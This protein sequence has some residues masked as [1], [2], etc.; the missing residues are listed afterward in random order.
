MQY[1]AYLNLAERLITS[2]PNAEGWRT[3][4]SRSYYAAFHAAIDFLT[5][6][7]VQLP[8]NI[9][10]DHVRVSTIL[11]NC[12]DADIDTYGNMLANLRGSRVSADYYFDQF[13]V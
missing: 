9:G 5:R 1:I 10:S 8:K 13:E 12:R 3:S 11:K 4:V 2:E 7:G 6:A